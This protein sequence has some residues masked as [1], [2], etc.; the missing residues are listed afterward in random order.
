MGMRCEV[1]AFWALAGAVRSTSLY[2][3]SCSTY[4]RMRARAEYESGLVAPTGYTPFGGNLVLVLSKL[5]RARPICLRLFW[6]FT[7]AA[8]SRTFW[9]A[10]SRRPIRMAMMAMTTKSSMS[11]KAGRGRAAGGE[12]RISILKKQRLRVG[13]RYS[14][15][16]AG[17]GRTP[18]PG[19]GSAGK[20]RGIGEV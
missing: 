5:C 16:D 2:R 17:G 6:H 18:R 20:S 12:V 19:V 10:G 13:V 9:T 4:G 11:V 15:G 1:T 14:P 3:L 7:R 8:A